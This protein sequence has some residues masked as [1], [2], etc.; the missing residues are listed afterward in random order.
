MT[1]RLGSLLTDDDGDRY[2]INGTFP[3]TTSWGED[4]RGFALTLIPEGMTTHDYGRK[5]RRR[6]DHPT[7]YELIEE[8]S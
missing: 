7:D 2:I 3:H 6:L 5:F 8:K 4:K 1:I